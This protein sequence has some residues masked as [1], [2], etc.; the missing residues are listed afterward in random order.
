MLDVYLPPSAN[1]IKH[2]IAVLWNNPAYF[3]P[4][5]HTS[6]ILLIRPDPY[7]PPDF[8]SIK[9]VLHSLHGLEYIISKTSSQ[10]CLPD[11]FR[12]TNSKVIDDTTYGHN[13]YEMKIVNN[14]NRL[15]VID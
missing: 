12:C 1:Y 13:N 15:L 3:Q 7:H 5:I 14:I 11:Q 2:N 10:A 9:S 8:L 4:S 6:V